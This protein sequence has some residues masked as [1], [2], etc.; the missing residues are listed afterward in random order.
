M[1]T[2]ALL[3]LIASFSLS[4]C[5]RIQPNVEAQATV[6]TKESKDVHYCAG[7]TKAGD[8]CKRHVKNDGGYCYQHAQQSSC[9]RPKGSQPVEDCYYEDGDTTRP[10]DQ[11][12][13]PDPAKRAKGTVTAHAGHWDCSRA[14][15]KL[16]EFSTKAEAEKA[17]GY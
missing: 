8:R 4:G 15:Q 13:S 3:L 10:I 9:Y 2:L 17:C 11:G 1:K 5:Q 14:G 16:V 12:A 6:K 7:K